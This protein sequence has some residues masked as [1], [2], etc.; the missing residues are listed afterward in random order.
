[1]ADPEFGLYPPS[2]LERPWDFPGGARKSRW[3]EESIPS[4]T[5]PLITGRPLLDGW[6]FKRH[7]KCTEYFNS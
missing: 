3:G 2:G 7:L 4:T 5:S 1:M 6:H